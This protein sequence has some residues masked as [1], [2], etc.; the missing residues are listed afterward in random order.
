[1]YDAHAT[2]AAW[3]TA[4]HSTAQLAADISVGLCTIWVAVTCSLGSL[5]VISHLFAVASRLQDSTYKY[6]EV[7]LVDPMH[8]AV[9]NVSTNTAYVHCLHQSLAQRVQKQL[10][11]SVASSSASVCTVNTKK[12]HVIPWIASAQDSLVT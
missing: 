11:C 9:R 8:N 5:K 10:V 6:F 3:A 7:I 2:L 1:M 12:H 4:Q